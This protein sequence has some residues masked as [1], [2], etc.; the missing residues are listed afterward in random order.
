M[1]LICIPYAYDK[2]KNSGVNLSKNCNTIGIYL[3]NAAVALFSAKHFNPDCAIAFATNLTRQELP[4]EFLELVD[5][6]QILVFEIPFD[7]YVFSGD[8]PWSL[9][10]Y[11]LCVL[12]KISN[13]EYQAICY[14]DTD[15]YVQGSFEAIWQEC[16]QHIMLYDIDHGLHTPDYVS[17]C[18]EVAEYFCRQKFITHYGGEFFAATTE[19]ARAFSEMCKE[20]YTEMVKRNIVTRKGDEYILSIAADKMKVNIKNAGAYIYRFWTGRNFRL[21]STCYKYNRIPILHVPNEKESGMISLYNRYIKHGFI[22]NDQQVW[23]ELRIN[24]I[25]LIDKVKN[26][27]EKLIKK[28]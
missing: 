3:K 26:A 24:R 18:D 11:K 27:L 13:M 9:A 22:P 10:Y 17:L 7:D 6:W 2:N 8:Y 1:N 19:N 15:V 5:K 12:Q 25:P 16:D 4:S 28:H 20:I 14:C 21:I 23:K